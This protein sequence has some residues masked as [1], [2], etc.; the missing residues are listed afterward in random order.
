MSLSDARMK[1]EA[2]VRGLGSRPVAAAHVTF[3]E[4]WTL[5]F[6]PRRKVRWSEPTE[7]GYDQYMSTYL[8]PTFG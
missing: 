6:K 7:A 3:K 2:H 5:H 1:I 8:L 4:Y